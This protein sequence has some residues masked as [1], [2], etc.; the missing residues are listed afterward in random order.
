MGIS[1]KQWDVHLVEHTRECLQKLRPV[2]ARS[3]TMEHMWGVWFTHLTGRTIKTKRQISQPSYTHTWAN[4]QKSMRFQ[5]MRPLDRWTCLPY[6]LHLLPVFP[7]ASRVLL[8]LHYHSTNFSIPFVCLPDTVLMSGHGALEEVSVI[9]W[10]NLYSA[11]CLPYRQ[12][13]EYDGT[14]LIEMSVHSSSYELFVF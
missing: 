12:I 14:Y 4:T 11:F 1:V 7:F 13:W 9:N 10:C 3:V 5:L 2:C 8:F 6:T